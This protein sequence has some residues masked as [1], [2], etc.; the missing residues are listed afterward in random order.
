ML[1][2]THTGAMETARAAFGAAAIGGPE[3]RQAPAAHLEVRLRRRVIHIISCQTFF[4][5]VK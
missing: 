3:H 2:A 1:L 5:W 4:T